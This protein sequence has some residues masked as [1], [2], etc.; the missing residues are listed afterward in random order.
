MN[1]DDF[2]VTN[3]CISFCG[4]KECV[5]SS[6]NWL[7][8]CFYQCPATVYYIPRFLSE[9]DESM[10]LSH[11]DNTPKPKWTQLSNRRLINYGGVPHRNGMITEAMPS[12]LQ[13]KVTALNNMGTITTLRAQFMKQVDIIV[14][15]I[16]L[17]RHIRFS[18]SKPR[19]GKWIFARPRNYGTFRRTTIP[20]SHKY[21]FMWLAYGAAVF[22][23]RCWSRKRKRTNSWKSAIDWCKPMES[24]KAGV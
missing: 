12:W 9:N 1:I 18:E 6:E 2:K 15:F 13:E 8:S 20:S 11:I 5:F 22:R 14:A 16:P 17:H 10:I 24:T 21:N 23:Q 4:M 7:F 3:V 19:S